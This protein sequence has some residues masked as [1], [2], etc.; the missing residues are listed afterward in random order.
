MWASSLRG[1]ALANAWNMSNDQGEACGE[2]DATGQD[3]S[4]RGGTLATKIQAGSRSRGIS[5]LSLSV[6]RSDSKCA[7]S[8]GSAFAHS[9]LI[10]G[11]W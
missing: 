3:P 2:G 4:A 5:S 6:A 10:I 1:C 9:E 11:R 7:S 8:Y